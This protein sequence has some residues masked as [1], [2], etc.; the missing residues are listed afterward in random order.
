MPRRGSNTKPASS[1]P[2]IAPER[3]GESELA[4]RLSRLAAF[5]PLRG[6]EKGEEH[7]GQD[8]RRQHQPKEQRER[9]RCVAGGVRRAA[10]AGV[11]QGVRQLHRDPGR[12]SDQRREALGLRIAAQP[13]GGDH[14]AG[15]DTEENGGQHGGENEAGP[16][17]EQLQKAE[18]DDLQPQ[19]CRACQKRGPEQAPRARAERPCAARRSP[20]DKS[21]PAVFSPARRA[22]NSATAAAA[23]LSAL[24]ATAVPRWPSNSISH[25]SP[26]RA[27][28]MPPRVFQPY[29]SPNPRPKLPSPRVMALASSGNVRPIAVAGTIISEKATVRRRRLTS[30]ACARTCVK[31]R[32]RTGLKGGISTTIASPVDADDTF[33]DSVE[34]QRPPQAL[35]VAGRYRVPRGQPRHEARQDDVGGQHAV[36]ERET[37]DAEP[38]GLEQDASRSREEEDQAQ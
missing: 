33:D 27:P 7:S 35:A 9:R 16:E 25:S 6:P 10:N 26:H 4:R 13:A 12:Q 11:E 30:Q 34:L 28:A 3:V 2:T 20:A 1:A 31:S 37:G 32:P 22:S 21:E 14:A 23:R 29:N 24:A 19:Q 8:R 18:P 17:D 36:A 15:T 38:Q 5:L